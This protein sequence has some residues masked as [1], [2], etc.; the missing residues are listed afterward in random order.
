MRS[1]GEKKNK[2]GIGTDQNKSEI[3]TTF[4]SKAECYKCGQKYTLKTGSC[5]VCANCGT[6][7]GCS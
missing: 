5:F 2:K 4:G 1:T 3:T 7:N 6:S